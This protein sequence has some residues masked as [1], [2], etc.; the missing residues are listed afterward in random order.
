[1]I[2]GSHSGGRYSVGRRRTRYR[3]I[4]TTNTR[5]TVYMENNLVNPASGTIRPF[6]QFAQQTHAHPH[7]ARRAYEYLRFHKQSRT[8]RAALET[9]GHTKPGLL[10]SLLS[11]NGGLAEHERIAS[12][13]KQ[14][15]VRPEQAFV[16]HISSDAEFWATAGALKSIN[17]N[18]V[19]DAATTRD[20]PV[21]YEAKMACVRFMVDAL[22]DMAQKLRG[23]LK[24]ANTIRCTSDWALEA[25][26]WEL[27]VRSCFLHVLA[28]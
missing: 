12:R 9:I 2:Q 8:S 21:T 17:N 19:V 26:A 15:T 14:R 1:M 11:P 6:E 7:F 28:S 16:A 27:L 3:R 5:G 24:E 4:T 10:T 20:I 25:V 23:D 22:R 18:P 13:R